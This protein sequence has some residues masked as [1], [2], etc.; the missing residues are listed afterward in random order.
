MAAIA[1]LKKDMPLQDRETVIGTPIVGATSPV[2]KRRKRRSPVKVTG[3]TRVR[4]IK[5]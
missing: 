5:L 2:K 4:A 3:Y 1:F